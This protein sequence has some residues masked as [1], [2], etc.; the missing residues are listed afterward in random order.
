MYARD[1]RRGETKRLISHGKPYHFVSAETISR[2]IKCVLK[3]SGNYDNIFHGHIIRSTSV[4]TEN[5][6]RADI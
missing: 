2:R 4:S 1:I 6:F 3:L 5:F